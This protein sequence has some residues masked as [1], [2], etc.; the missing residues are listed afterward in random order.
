MVIQ[1]ID[2]REKAWGVAVG[3]E[4]GLWEVRSWFGHTYLTPAAEANPSE[5]PL[6]TD[7]L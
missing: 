1:T 6:L 4:G 7:R 3:Q 2:W 5:S